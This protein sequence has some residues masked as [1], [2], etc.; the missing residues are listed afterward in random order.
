MAA[1]RASQLKHPSKPPPE[2]P[3]MSKETEL[4]KTKIH[5]S[6][7]SAGLFG[8]VMQALIE[9]GGHAGALAVLEKMQA[10][11]AHVECRAI[12]NK[13]GASFEGVYYSHGNTVGQRL[14]AATLRNAPS[15]LH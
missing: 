14:F 4:E 15:E 5:T 2:S 8:L 13:S 10:G 9:D 1:E 12:F 7:A 3:K 11:H 6:A